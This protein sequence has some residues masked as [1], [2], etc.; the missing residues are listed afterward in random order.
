MCE[1]GLK[2]KGVSGNH[3]RALL[4]RHVDVSSL[5]LAEFFTIA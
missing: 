1:L 2:P 4:G 3:W 5:A